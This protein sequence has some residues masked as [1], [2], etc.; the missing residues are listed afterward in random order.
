MA[1]IV[2]AVKRTLCRLIKSVSVEL[3][4]MLFLQTPTEDSHT[5][6]TRQIL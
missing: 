3:N 1:I 2:V 6:Q 5:I 4:I